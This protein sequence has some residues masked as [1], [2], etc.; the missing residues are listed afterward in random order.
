MVEVSS[1]NAANRW[2]PHSFWVPH[3]G[4]SILNGERVM[5]GARIGMMVIVKFLAA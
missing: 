2:L 1:G 5:Q 3:L 4:V